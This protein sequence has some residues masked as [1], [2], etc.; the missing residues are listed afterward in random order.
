MLPYS[1]LLLLSYYMLELLLGLQIKDE[2]RRSDQMREEV[3]VTVR[4]QAAEHIHQR[5]Q[6]RSNERGYSYGAIRYYVYWDMSCP[7]WG[8]VPVTRYSES[9]SHMVSSRSSP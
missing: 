4:Q 8:W 6:Q 1:W 3:Y 7:L 2:I 9:P 5:T